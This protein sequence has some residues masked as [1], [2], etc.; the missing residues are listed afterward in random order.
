MIRRSSVMFPSSFRPPSRS[1]DRGGV[2]HPRSPR[3]LS[4]L[5]EPHDP[6]SVMHIITFLSI[7]SVCHDKKE[8]NPKDVIIVALGSIQSIHKISHALFLT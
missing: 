1:K 6:S 8:S 2:E 3:P 4:D 5:F 7:S